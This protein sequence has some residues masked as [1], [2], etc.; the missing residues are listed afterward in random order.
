MKRKPR[1]TNFLKR[2]QKDAKMRSIKRR[3]QSEKSKLKK[4]SIEYKR[5]LKAVSRKL[6]RK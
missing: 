1:K 4:L 5:T 6:K 2:V 3:I